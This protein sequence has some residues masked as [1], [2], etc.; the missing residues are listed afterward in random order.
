MSLIQLAD[1]GNLPLHQDLDSETL[2]WIRKN[3]PNEFK[4]VDFSPI[5]RQIELN[6]IAKFVP[7][8]TWFTSPLK[9]NSLHGIRHLMRVTIYTYY[10]SLSLPIDEKLTNSL[11]I[12]A[13][14]HDIRREDDKGDEGHADRGAEWYGKND[15]SVLK[16]YEVGNIDNSFVGR[17][18]SLHE[19]SDDKLRR[20]RF[21]VENYQTVDVLKAADALDRYIQP[22]KKWWIDDKYLRLVPSIELKVFAYNLILRSEGKYLNGI[23]SKEATL[24]SLIEMQS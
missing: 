3:E 8:E 14:L 19:F 13:S 16:K 17:L 10:L 18:I 9:V 2:N 11:L 7:L 12:A 20:N 5:A 6:K 15:S 23:N 21:Y 22:K 24:T 4:N 1:R